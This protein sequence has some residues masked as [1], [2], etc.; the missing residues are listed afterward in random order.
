MDQLKSLESLEFWRLDA[1]DDQ[2]EFLANLRCLKSLELNACEGVTDRLLTEVISH[3][4]NLEHLSISNTPITK[5]AE[6]TLAGM[7]RLKSLSVFQSG[8]PRA[9]QKRLE[10]MDEDDLYDDD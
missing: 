6:K 1:D 7:T 2:L 9:A 5:A 8:L 3:L 4:P 10:K